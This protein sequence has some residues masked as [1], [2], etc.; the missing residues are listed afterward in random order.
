MT[1]G[2]AQRTVTITYDLTPPQV[3]RWNT[4]GTDHKPFDSSIGPFSNGRRPFTLHVRGFCNPH[5]PGTAH[6]PD[7]D[8]AGNP[9]HPTPTFHVE[10]ITPAEIE[11]F[12]REATGAIESVW[13]GKI[14]LVPRDLARGLEHLSRPVPPPLEC[15]IELT[16]VNSAQEAHLHLQL[17]KI[18]Q[19]GRPHDRP[20]AV[21]KLGGANWGLDAWEW[22]CGRGNAVDMTLH[23]HQAWTPQLAVYH[24]ETDGCSRALTDM[25]P[26][27]GAVHRTRCRNAEAGCQKDVLALHQNVFA[28]EFGHYLGLPHVCAGRGA[29]NA[30]AEYGEGQGEAVLRD[31]MGI[32]NE[33]TPR[34]ATPWMQQL[35]GHG[36]FPQHAWKATSE[37]YPGER[38]IRTVTTRGPAPPRS[39]TPARR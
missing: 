28:H 1:F 10:P 16:W 13:N 2:V 9:I 23:V 14:F 18:L 37:A 27:N 39:A 3:E 24:V 30:A 5:P 6:I 33:V 38:Q 7:D 12:Q 8:M 17:L 29:L 34:V 22:F 21:C 15:R 19:D 32:G 31:I 11:R 4:S 35:P 36:Y 26:Q 20:R 25:I